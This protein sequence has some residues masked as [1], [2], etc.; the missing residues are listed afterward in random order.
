[1]CAFKCKTGFLNLGAREQSLTGW[2]VVAGI[3]RLLLNHKRRQ[4]SWPPEGKNSIRGQR[5]GLITQSFCVIEFYYSIMEIEKASD[6]EI[7]RGQKEY[8]LAHVSYI[9]FN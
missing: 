6:I 3:E 4:N 2:K 1:M 9:P 5:R 8:S 7:R